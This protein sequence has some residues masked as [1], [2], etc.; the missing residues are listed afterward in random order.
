LAGLR[1][2]FPHHTDQTLKV[3]LRQNNWNSDSAVMA[4]FDPD[5]EAKYLEESMNS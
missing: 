4:L 5:N 2:I 1:E 3:A